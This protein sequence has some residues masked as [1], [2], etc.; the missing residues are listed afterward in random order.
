VETSVRF[1]A[2]LRW[3]NLTIIFRPHAL[4]MAGPSVWNSLPDSLR[5]PA[6]SLQMNI[7]V[8]VK[9]NTVFW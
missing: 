5:D 4:S 7:S 1:A 6:H 9:G 2:Q 8:G 3:E